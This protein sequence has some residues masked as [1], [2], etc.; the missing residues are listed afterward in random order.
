[1]AK[2]GQ[3][4]CQELEISLCSPG[5]K[6]SYTPTGMGHALPLTLA[7]CRPGWDDYQDLSET[8][9]EMSQ[10][11]IDE[12]GQLEGAMLRG[13][14]LLKQKDTAQIVVLPPNN[15]TMF[16][17]TLEFPGSQHGLGTRDN[18]VNLSDTPTE[19]SHTATRPED[20]EPI[21]EVVMLGHFS[22][23]L[24]KM[25][26]SLLDLEDSY[27]KAL[28]EVIIETERV[29]W[30]ICHIDAHYI[31]QVVTVMASWQ[32]VIQTVATHMENV[33]LTIYL[34]HWEDARR[35]MREYV[36]VVIKA[37][38]ERDA[39]HSKEAETRKQAIK[40]GD[41]EDPVVRLLEAM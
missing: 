39:T 12:D 20:A 31:S 9:A 38:E 10:C 3:P 4:L 36:A 1:M 13:G 5:E 27:F 22:D 8:V 15:D 14:T 18:P 40:S 34:A 33:D 32:E 41:P 6:V 35:V 7:A 29:L 37:C 21:D 16:V 25:A 30:D 2:N 28:R 17:P 11:L 19:A 23:A 26:T 24:S